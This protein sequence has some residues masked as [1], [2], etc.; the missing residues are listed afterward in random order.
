M[1]FRFLVSFHYYKDTDLQA[2]VDSYEGPVEVFADSGAFSAATLGVTIKRADYAAW[3]KDWQHLITT[4]A[5]LDVIG[6]ADSTHR[7]TEALED[8]GLRV[9]PVFHT[10]SPWGRLERLCTKYPYVALGGMVPY[11][12][13]P[14]EVLRWL[15][16][17]FKIARNYGTV[18]HGFGQTRFKTL[19]SLPFY[20]VDSSSW[21]S[22]ARYGQM[23]L[24]DESKTRLLTL[25]TGVPAQARRHAALLRSHGANPGMVGRPG[26][27]VS[28]QRK[29]ERY[30]LEGCVMRGVPA[31]AFHRLGEWLTRRHQVQPPPG[32]SSPGTGLFLADTYPGSL[33][34]AAQA[35]TANLRKDTP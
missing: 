24:W 4:A 1:T 33:V 11:A 35:I 15:V 3:L 31:V 32:L 30:A 19:T 27:A 5:T 25:P 2:I 12:R 13:Y 29:H 18:F 22:G 34:I 28:K 8:M 10:G 16:R 21:G 14:D 7:N 20:S 9:L 23:Y 17:C 6:D 26:F